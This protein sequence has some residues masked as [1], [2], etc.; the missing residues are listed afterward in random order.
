MPKYTVKVG[1]KVHKFDGLGAAIAF[2]QKESWDKA[3]PMKVIKPDGQSIDV[4]IVAK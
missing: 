1:N 3:Q 4:N 2:A